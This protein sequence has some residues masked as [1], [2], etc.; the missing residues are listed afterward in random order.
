M[1]AKDNAI[2]FA[3]VVK[4]SMISNPYESTYNLIRVLLENYFSE[5]RFLK[6][7]TYLELM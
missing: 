2:K 5:P 6:K 4:V 7:M 1:P 3:T